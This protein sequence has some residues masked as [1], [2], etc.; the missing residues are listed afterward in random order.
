MATTFRYQGRI[1]M[2]CHL[3]KSEV[4][5]SSVFCLQCGAR[6]DNALNASI[7]QSG[8]VTAQADGNIS[9]GNDIVGRD[10]IVAF[11]VNWY[12]A[13]SA[14]IDER[15]MQ[16]AIDWLRN[17]YDRLER[18]KFNPK[19]SYNYAEK[20]ADAAALS[21]LDLYKRGRFLFDTRQYAEATAYWA[22]IGRR[23]PSN[24]ESE[25]YLR[26]CLS[27]VA[28]EIR[29]ESAV[30]ALIGMAVSASALGLHESVISYVDQIFALSPENPE[31]KQLLKEAQSA[32]RS[33][34]ERQSSSRE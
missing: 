19:S 28:R 9:V 16:E 13:S 21:N 24:K 30:K 2:E 23:E 10:K 31:A 8:G 17:K 32:I 5:E 22:E 29:V 1:N 15:W 27:K 26:L 33:K 20:E 18:Y 11:H 3:C 14:E 12:E 6:L 4:P 34:E 7:S 25:S